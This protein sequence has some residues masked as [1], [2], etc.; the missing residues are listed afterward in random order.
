MRRGR[1]L[2]MFT[3]LAP[4]LMLVDTARAEAYAFNGCRWN[5]SGSRE[6]SWIPASLDATYEGNAAW[7]ADGWTATAAGH[8]TVPEDTVAAKIAI[9]APNLGPGVVGAS[10]WSC[11]GGFFTG[12][13]VSAYNR[14]YTDGYVS[15][16]KRSVMVHELGHTLGLD[17]VTTSCTSPPS[18]MMQPTIA[19]YE[20][21]GWY[22]PHADDIS[23]IIARYP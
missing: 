18:G 5:I 6:I 20:T 2:L 17:H 22:G 23:G 7:A 19:W 16:K 1:V 9:S 14:Y 11:S 12:Q 8:I 13:P 10:S 15:A 21:C 4:S 3:A